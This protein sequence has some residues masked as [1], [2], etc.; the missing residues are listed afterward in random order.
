MKIEIPTWILCGS[1]DKF[2][3]I[4]EP[5]FESKPDSNPDWIYVDPSLLP[6]L[7][8]LLFLPISL[9]PPDAYLSL[10]LLA[11]TEGKTPPYTAVARRHLAKL[12]AKKIPNQNISSST[13]KNTTRPKKKGDP[14]KKKLKPTCCNTRQTSKGTIFFFFFNRR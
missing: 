13:N 7:G 2:E 3:N 5:V 6:L 9:S 4:Y 12:I 1:H 8:P 11:I 14:P 10:F